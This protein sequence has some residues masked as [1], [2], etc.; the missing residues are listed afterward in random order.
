MDSSITSTWINEIKFWVF[1]GLFFLVVLKIE[2]TPFLLW[3]ETKRKWY[4][5]LF[6]IT[7]IFTGAVV[8]GVTVPLVFKFLNI[9][10]KQDVLESVSNHYCS[11]FILLVFGCL[12][13]GVVEELV[14]RG[15]LMPRLE[16]FAKN[17]WL[18]IVLSSLIFG[19]AHLGNLSIVGLVVPTFIGLIFSYH[20]YKYRNIVVLILAHF[21]IDF[22]SFMTSC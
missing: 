17:G 20:Y 16:I 5:Y 1:L 15:Y 18:V 7:I 21:L 14:F 4:F 10:L 13:A 19:F 8:V 6:S 2:R 22:A 12:T 3:Q 9:S 11:S